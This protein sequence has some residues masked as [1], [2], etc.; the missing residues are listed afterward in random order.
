MSKCFVCSKDLEPCWEGSDAQFNDAIMF[1]ARGNYGSSVYDPVDSRRSLLINICDACLVER[2]DHV[3]E[4]TEDRPIPTVAFTSW[5][6]D[7][8]AE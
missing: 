2:R 5:N 7:K 4:A 1:T 6:P 8:A 3:L